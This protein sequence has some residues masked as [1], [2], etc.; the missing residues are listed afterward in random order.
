MVIKIHHLCWFKSHLKTHDLKDK[1]L[2]ESRKIMKSYE[3]FDKMLCDSAILV[4][5]L[6]SDVNIAYVAHYESSCDLKLSKKQVKSSDSVVPVDVIGGVYDFIDEDTITSVSASLSKHEHAKMFHKDYSKCKFVE[7][8]WF[9]RNQYER[10][11]RKP[12]VQ[13][14]NTTI[15]TNN[16]WRP[17]GIVNGVDGECKSVLALMVL[18]H[19]ERMD[20]F[21]FILISLGF[22]HGE[23]H[24][25][26]VSVFLSDRDPQTIN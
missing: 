6:S 25:Q 12:E 22:V 15:K 10:A 21:R 1:D 2:G 8:S 19:N 17:L 7:T 24:M 3:E 9:S 11:K 26:C 20:A 5:F 23:K 13:M 4:K 16:K 14:V 18:L